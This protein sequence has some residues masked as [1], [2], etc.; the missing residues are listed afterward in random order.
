MTVR[1][2]VLGGTFNP[3]HLAHLIAAREVREAL[4]LDSVLL[5]PTAHHPF[6]GEA[7]A[8]PRHRAAMVELAVA[9]DDALAAERME[10]E[11]GGVSYTVDTLRA[12]RE[13]E[14]DTIWHLIVGRDNLADLDR[15]REAERLP[16]L[17]H[18]VVIT[19]GGEAPARL[20]FEGRSSLVP[21]PR[22][23]ISSTAIRDRVA[24]GLS[25]RYWVPPAVEAYI[26]QHAL[27]GAARPAPVDA[28][29]S[30]R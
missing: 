27:Y 8:A 20:P 17:A 22:L 25:I 19:R 30:R 4:S 9:G 12:L 10:V 3:P 6:K 1:R 24:A 28:R 13:R 29:P 16:D 2:G 15:W 7:A 23:E 18:L 26:R 14:P 21:V 11:R 5:V